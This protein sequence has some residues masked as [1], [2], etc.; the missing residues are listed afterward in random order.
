MPEWYLLPYYAILRAI[1]DKLMGV[2]ALGGAIGVLFI[3]PWLDTSKVRSM[4]YRPMARWFFFIFI[5]A[6]LVARLVRR[7]TS[8]T[9]R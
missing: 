1:P 6:C 2:I 8:P 5:V 7:R 4:R 3:L 9:P